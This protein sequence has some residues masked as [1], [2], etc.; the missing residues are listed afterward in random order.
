MIP[1]LMFLF[2]VILSNGEADTNLPET[3]KNSFLV[4]AEKERNYSFNLKKDLTIYKKFIVNKSFSGA[5]LWF[6]PFH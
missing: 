3:A 2:R 5:V 6:W 1:S 4:G